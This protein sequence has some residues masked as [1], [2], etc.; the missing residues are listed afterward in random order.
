MPQ[1]HF[2]HDPKAMGSLAAKIHLRRQSSATLS[3]APSMILAR[4]A[5][6]H[7]FVCQLLDWIGIDVWWA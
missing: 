3:I 5:Q 4:S 1:T 2:G 6:H 7:R